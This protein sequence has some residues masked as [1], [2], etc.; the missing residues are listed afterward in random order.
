MYEILALLALFALVY[1]S[2]ADALNERSGQLTLGKSMELQPGFFAKI[3]SGSRRGG[4]GLVVILSEQPAGSV[5][6]RLSPG[7]PM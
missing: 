2:I 1:S 7:D 3:E 6:S 4:E 5:R